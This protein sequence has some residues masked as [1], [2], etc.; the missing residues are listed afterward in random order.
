MAS[1]AVDVIPRAEWG[2]WIGKIGNRRFVQKI[3]NQGNVGSCAT[4][5]TSQAVEITEIIA[6]REWVELN[7]WFIYYHTSG[8]A[9]RG[10]S[11]DENLVFVRD[12]GIAPEAVW[13]R[14]MGWTQKPSAD[15]YDA[16]KRH[17]ILEFYDV[18]SIDEFGTC[19]I[20]GWPVVFGWQGHSVVAVDLITASIFEYANSWAPSWGDQGFGKLAL[21]SV[22]WRY[23][24]FAVRVVTQTI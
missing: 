23:G 5:S 14:S 16:A 2:E 17:R 15:A 12:N 9:D 1:T 20:E 7:P 8:G 24:A 4:E 6:G 3:K 21:S 10:S 11:I 22:D 13:P 19:L 18:S